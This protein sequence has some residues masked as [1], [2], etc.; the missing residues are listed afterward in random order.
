MQASTGARP[1]AGLHALR[2]RLYDLLR[3]LPV[4][5]NTEL[6]RRVLPVLR[7]VEIARL[8]DEQYVVAIT[9]LQGVGKTTLIRAIYGLPEDLL[10]EGV[11][12]GEKVPIWVLEHSVGGRGGAPRRGGRGGARGGRLERARRGRKAR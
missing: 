5:D 3:A 8:L 1:Q 2:D 4:L 7:K 6:E 9:G 10:P 12:R 11:G